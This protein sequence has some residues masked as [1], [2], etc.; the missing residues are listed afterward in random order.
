MYQDMSL[1]FQNLGVSINTALGPDA[2]CF[3]EFERK[4]INANCF[5]QLTIS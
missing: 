2:L 1:K 5:D 3:D 4:V